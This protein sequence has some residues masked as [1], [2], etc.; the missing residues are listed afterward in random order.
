MRQSI[1]SCKSSAFCLLIFFLYKKKPKPTSTKTF[2]L[3]KPNSKVEN[4]LKGSFSFF[5]L[6]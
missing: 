4:A 6:K 1:G 5:F 3:K 2:L